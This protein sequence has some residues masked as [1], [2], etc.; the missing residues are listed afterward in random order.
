[1]KKNKIMFVANSAWSMSR[2]RSE[3]LQ[4]Y[5]AR[6]FHVTVVAPSDASV[7]KI[8][9]IGCD[10][11]S[12]SMSRRSL[13][14]F[15]DLWSFLQLFY[16]YFRH[17]P[18]FIFHY[19]IKPNI[20]GSFAASV[21]RIQN[22]PVVT[23]LGYVFVKESMLTQL[24]SYLYKLAFKSTL[25]T[26]FLNTDDRD[27]F[28][29]RK[30]IP[31]QKTKVLP[32][33]GINLT[34]YAYQPDFPSETSFLLIA[35]MLWD[36]GVGEFVDAAREFKK[37]QPEVKFKLLG[38]VDLGNPSG[39]PST[40]IEAWQNEGVIEY[41]EEK[42]DV[43]Q[44][45]K[46]STCIVLPSYREGIPRVLLEA[47]AVGRPVITY[48]VPGCREAV[49]DN[50][51]GFLVSPKNQSELVEATRKITTM[52]TSELKLLGL[53]GRSYMASKFSIEKILDQYRKKI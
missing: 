14:P 34:E 3:V 45:I 8:R 20:W 53:A 7:D 39:I 51:S 2:F 47:A 46:D 52:K 4:D 42:K 33:E 30:I 25:E 44:D 11:L 26:W 23:G 37:Q 10:F 35:R 21:L 29:K 5:I 15:I 50:Q 27:E 36:K 18:S 13:N 40:Q 12:F 43:R 28:V 41:L 22:I 31:T 48:D 9:Q 1:M 16:I 49:I 17:R 38:P 24:V 19:T 6:G 32:G